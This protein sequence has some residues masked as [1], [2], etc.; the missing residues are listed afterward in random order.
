M[1]KYYTAAVNLSY[2]SQFSSASFFSRNAKHCLPLTVT[3]LLY[4]CT[5]C[6]RVVALDRQA[7]TTQKTG[8]CLY[9]H[10]PRCMPSNRCNNG[11]GAWACLAHALQCLCDGR[12]CCPARTMQLVIFLF[13][14]F[15]RRRHP[16]VSTRCATGSGAR[17]HTRLPD[18]HLVEFSYQPV[19]A[20]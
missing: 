4:G 20:Q 16:V 19:P 5:T 8:A 6:T 15:H 9:R 11:H 2:I 3:K 17:V 7:C 18:F 1:Y 13:L 12:A 14:R 10:T